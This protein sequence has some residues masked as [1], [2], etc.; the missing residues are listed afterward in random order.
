MFRD[1]ASLDGIHQNHK[2]VYEHTGEVVNLNYLKEISNTPESKKTLDVFLDYCNEYYRLIHKLAEYIEN[3]QN[4]PDY[5]SVS[6]KMAEDQ[7]NY[8]DLVS[9]RLEE[10]ILELESE[11]KDISWADRI[12]NDRREIGRFAALVGEGE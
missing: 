8:H 3:N 2:A 1:S 6:K 4:D 12:R 7:S 10:F 11:K 5:E 9:V